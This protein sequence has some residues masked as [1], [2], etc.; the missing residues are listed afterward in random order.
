MSASIATLI[1]D[2]RP[3]MFKVAIF[4]WA[5]YAG[6]GGWGGKPGAF[7]HTLSFFNCDALVLI[8]LRTFWGS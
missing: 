1:G 3:L 7:G 2:V 4:I 5:I 8:R 6:Y